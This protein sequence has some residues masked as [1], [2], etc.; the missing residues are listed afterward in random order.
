MCLCGFGFKASTSESTT[1][2]AAMI[3]IRRYI[4]YL[5]S[6]RT[7]S[8]LPM[9]CPESQPFGKL[10]RLR[11]CLVGGAA[12]GAILGKLPLQIAASR[13]LTYALWSID[14]ACSTVLSNPLGYSQ[15]RWKLGA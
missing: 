9:K 7:C 11:P 1:K 8:T 6:A 2:I 13:F 10:K 14:A 5:Y 4:L 3:T 15:C 12:A